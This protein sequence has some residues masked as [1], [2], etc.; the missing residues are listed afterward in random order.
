MKNNEP[1]N[2]NSDSKFIKCINCRQDILASK[3]FLHEGFCNRNNIFCDHCGKVFLKKDYK[4]H[5]KKKENKKPEILLKENKKN[6]QKEIRK[7]NIY[8][9]PIITRRKPAFEFI[10]M[11]M[12]EQY[13]INNPIIITEDGKIIKTNINQNQNEY[14]L[15]YFGINNVKKNNANS[16]DF[17]GNDY[18]LNQTDLYKENKPII[19]NNNLNFEIDFKKSFKNSVSMQNLN[20]NKNNILNDFS[21]TGQNNEKINQKNDNFINFNIDENNN[22]NINL[23]NNNQSSLINNLS[24]DNNHEKNYFSD[25]FDDLNNNIIINNNII[26]YNSNNNINKIHNIYNSKD[27]LEKSPSFENNNNIVL[28]PVFNKSI[29]NDENKTNYNATRISNKEEK[30]KFNKKLKKNIIDNT[31]II[32]QKEPIDSKSKKILEVHRFSPCLLEKE[33]INNHSKKKRG[34]KPKVQSKEVKKI[35]KSSKLCEFCNSLVD[36]LGMHYQYYHLKK[37]TELLSPNKRDTALL[38]EKLNSDNTEEKGIEESNKKILLREFKP[39]L[40]SMSIEVQNKNHLSSDKYT[41]NNKNFTKLEKVKKVS[42]NR[43]FQTDSTLKKNKFPDDNTKYKYL[44][45]SSDQNINQKKFEEITLENKKLSFITK[46]PQNKIN[47]NDI[48]DPLYFFTE[49]RKHNNRY[50]NENSI[51]GSFI[52][53]KRNSFDSNEKL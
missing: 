47:H 31:N 20:V 2:S 52:D 9:S 7:I 30:E 22:N 28:D 19:N 48:F 10:E 29:P 24:D 26:T 5:F 44:N 40:H 35:K 41:N 15:S 1:S 38:N 8:R 21:L 17:Y 16:N 36:D 51:Y 37:Y 25:N 53:F 11:P 3:M 34:I 43:L 46:S 18:I 42:Y 14:L 27:D 45:R 23:L 39:N 4:A 50:N 32:Y 49:A 13:K 6:N 33:P 12:T